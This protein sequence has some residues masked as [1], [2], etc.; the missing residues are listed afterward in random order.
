VRRLTEVGLLS[1]VLVGLS[2]PVVIDW[3]EE[4]L[5]RLQQCHRDVPTSG[6]Q[7]FESPCQA[8]NFRVLG[9]AGISVAQLEATLGSAD[10]CFDRDASGKKKHPDLKACSD[11]AWVFYDLPRGSVG[12]GPNL[13]CRTRDGVICWV[14]TWI[15]TARRQRVQGKGR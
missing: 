6:K 15:Y 5:T 3:R 1:L 2:I 8:M 14:V 12:G 13:W 4:T 11:P 10:E 9:L 7:F